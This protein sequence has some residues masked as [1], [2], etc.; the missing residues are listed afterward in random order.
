M[1]TARG[2]TDKQT[3]LAQVPAF[4]AAAHEL[5]APLG[6][7]RQLSLIL[8]DE[9]RETT[10]AEKDVRRILE[11]ITLTSER[12]LRLVEMLT[13]QARLEE[14][15]FELEPV[16]V[17]RLCEEVAHELSPLCRALDR[18]IEVKTPRRPLLAVAN[19]DLLQSI[20]M[21]LCDNALA[22]APSARPVLL[23]VRQCQG[24]V[25]LG[26][27]DYGPLIPADVFRG[28]QDRLGVSA[29][30]IGNRPGSSGLG[31]YVAGQFAQAMH[32]RLGVQRHRQAGTSFYVDT[33]ESAQLSFLT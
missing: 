26:V 28:L 23:T 32:A 6:L 29:Q 18:R 20:V 11:R 16:H 17:G 8:Q 5:K 19:R 3:A 25:R 2:D 27:R 13:R 7:V 30:P 24:R 4:V 14:G 31:L 33:Q 22:H 10:L 1:V 12:S 15:L 21:S 9:P